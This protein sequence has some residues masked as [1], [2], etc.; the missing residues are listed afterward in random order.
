MENTGRLIGQI[1]AEAGCTAHKAKIGLYLRDVAAQGRS[2]Q[3]ASA[4][5]RKKPATVKTLAREFM[6][7]FSDYRPFAKERD[8]GAIIEP[9]T[10]LNLG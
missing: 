3:Q 8:K 1:A 5:L 10:V 7:D 6:I 9:R 4:L 2:L